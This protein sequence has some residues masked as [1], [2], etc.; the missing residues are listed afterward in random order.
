MLDQDYKELKRKIDHVNQIIEN[1]TVFFEVEKV[2]F[3]EPI[4]KQ[5]QYIERI[6]SKFSKKRSSFCIPFSLLKMQLQYNN[7]YINY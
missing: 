4:G 2:Q 7:L 3:N 6:Y 5:Q 1:V